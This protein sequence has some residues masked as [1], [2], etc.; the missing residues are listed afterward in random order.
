MTGFRS[1]QYSLK[2]ILGVSLLLLAVY[3]VIFFGKI[4]ILGAN[5]PQS[6]LQIPEYNMVECKTVNSQAKNVFRVLLLNPTHAAKIVEKA[7]ANP[8]ISE[9][10]AGLQVYWRHEKAHERDLVDPFFDLLITHQETL[11][12]TRMSQRYRRIAQLP[13]S[14][15]AFIS[16]KEKPELTLGY[17][18]NKTVGLL[19]YQYSYFGHVFPL[20][21]IKKAGIQPKNLNIVY[22]TKHRE[23]IDGLESG[24][25][26]VI[27]SYYRESTKINPVGCKKKDSNP[28]F[29]QTVVR[30]N[31]PGV[32][33]YLKDDHDL[34][35]PI[36]CFSICMAIESKRSSKC[37]PY[38]SQS[39]IIPNECA[40]RGE[41][42]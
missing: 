7:C 20:V 18:Q 34:E 16:L 29:I 40:C 25:L 9:N 23:L 35:S 37:D 21:E 22:K 39:Q 17:L 8:V 19:Q 15:V 13:D 6:S 12:E 11:N 24:E 38:F 27:G 1:A 31:V 30:K 36:G 42:Q 41:G 10:Y 32:G 14:S 5:F 3:A 4:A 28:A 26:D 33:W 2:A